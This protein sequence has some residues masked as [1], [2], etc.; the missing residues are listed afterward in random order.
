MI[1]FWLEFVGIFVGLTIAAELLAKGIDELEDYLGQGMSGGIVMGLLTA[2]PETIFVIIA[3]ISGHY[4]IALGSAIG[5][6]VILFTLGIGLVGI[7]YKLKWGTNLII[8]EE[9]KVENTFL[10]LST[11]AIILVLLYGI[12]NIITGLI[13]ISIY[14]YYVLYRVN[15][16]RKEKN[17]RRKIATRKPFIYLT[18]GS[19]LLIL[20]SQPFVSYISV[21]SRIFN[22]PAIWLSLFISPIAAELEEKLSAIRLALMSKS[23]GSLSILGF[24][25]SKVENATLLVGLIGILNDYPLHSALTEVISMVIANLIALYILF[26]RKLNAVESIIL[27]L[28]YAVI[29]IASLII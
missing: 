10:F 8:S 23:G 24:V 27:I 13:L 5:G 4:D 17:D 9:Y 26:D 28:S 16:F 3:S 29:I 1:L 15:K 6:N 20:L 25:G 18:I 19:V 12:L 22:V 2:L 11:L 7:I 21:L 14:V